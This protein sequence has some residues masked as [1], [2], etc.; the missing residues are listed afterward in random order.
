MPK[1]VCNFLTRPMEQQAERLNASKERVV[2]AHNLI[3][4]SDPQNIDPSD[5]QVQAVID[6]A[7]KR[8]KEAQERLAENKK[9]LTKDFSSTLVSIAPFRNYEGPKLAGDLS[10]AVAIRNEQIALEKLSNTYR[11]AAYAVAS[12][13]GLQIE[14]FTNTRGSF[15]NTVEPSFAITFDK[16]TADTKADE[17]LLFT[18]LMSDLGYEQQKTAYVTRYLSS[19]EDPNANAVEFSLRTNLATKTGNIPVS[20]ISARLRSMMNEEGLADEGFAVD[21]G[22]NEIRFLVADAEESQEAFQEKLGKYRKLLARLQSEILNK[23][24]KVEY[25]QTPAASADLNSDARRGIY[26]SWLDQNGSNHQK[27]SGDAREL[28]V[29][30]QRRAERLSAQELAERTREAYT[31]QANPAEPLTKEELEA[32]QSEVVSSMT[33]AA[34]A[35]EGRYLYRVAFQKDG[36]GNETM[37]I[38]TE[39][40]LTASDQTSTA[41]AKLHGTY[42]PERLKMR[43]D[44]LARSMSS[45]FELLA[46][47]KGKDI[48]SKI[49]EL[50]A[51]RSKAKPEEKP[52]VNRKIAK[53]TRDY[54][55]LENRNSGKPSARAAAINVVG[56]D[57]IVARLLS[58]LTLRKGTQTDYVATEYQKILDNFSAMQNAVVHRFAYLEG[59]ELRRNADSNIEDDDELG[60]Y[61]T[62]N[63][64]W[65]EEAHASDTFK[66]LSETVRSALKNCVLRENTPVTKKGKKVYPAIKDDL[67]QKMYMDPKA[68]YQEIAYVLSSM[69]DDSDFHNPA[70]DSYPALERMA[71]REGFSWVR[72]VVNYLKR[73]PDSAPLFYNAFRMDLTQFWHSD[74]LGR[75]KPV[76]ALPSGD[77]FLN[78]AKR[79]VQYSEKYADISL[80]DKGALSDFETIKTLS[81]MHSEANKI[82]NHKKFMESSEMQEEFA[83]DIANLI[84]ALGVNVSDDSITELVRAR[85]A[86]KEKHRLI[87]ATVEIG[88]IIG[89]AY[90]IKDPEKASNDITSSLAD[91]MFS[92][93]Y[94][95]FRRLGGEIEYFNGTSYQASFRD[96]GASFYAL[97]K[98]NFVTTTVKV[99]KLDDTQRRQEYMERMYRS[100]YFMYDSVN[101][102]KNVILDELWNPDN[103]KE[104]SILDICTFNS[105]AGHKFPQMTDEEIR[106]A[107]VSMFFTPEESGDSATTAAWYHVPNYSNA[108]SSDFIKYK[109]ER[110]KNYKEVLAG[111]IM[112]GVKQELNRIRLGQLRKE[113]LAQNTPDGGHSNLEEIARWDSNSTHFC[114]FPFF[115][116][117]TD[118]VTGLTLL[119]ASDKYYQDKDEKA[120]NAFIT[121]GIYA[122][123]RQTTDNYSYPLASFKDAYKRKAIEGLEKEKAQEL[124]KKISNI[125]AEEVRACL[126]ADD[127]TGFDKDVTGIVDL[128]ENYVW[129]TH[130]MLHQ[131]TEL[132]TCDLAFYKRGDQGVDLVKRFKEVTASGD[133]L[134]TQSK[135]GK[136][137]SAVIGIRDHDQT[138]LDY[139]Y[140][141]KSLQDALNEGRLSGPKGK[142]MAE[143]ILSHYEHMNITDGQSLRTLPS[144][145]SVM[146]MVGKWTPDLQD[147]YVRI[148]Q[149][150]YDEAD[151]YA[152]FVAIK[153][154]IFDFL[155]TET[156]VVGSEIG[157]DTDAPVTINVPTQYKDSEAVL[158]SLAGKLSGAFENSAKARGLERFMIDYGI[159][160][161][162]FESTTKVGL[163]GAIDLRYS[164]SFLENDAQRKA[165]IEKGFKEK[166]GEVPASWTDYMDF[167]REEYINSLKQGKISQ[168]AFN[169]IMA[170]MEPTEDEVYDLLSEATTPF[171]NEDVLPNGVQWVQNPNP[172]KDWETDGMSEQQAVAYRQNRGM[173]LNPQRVKF[174]DNRDYRIVQP[175]REHLF[176]TKVVLGVQ[177]KNLITA[178]LPENF[179]MT[180]RGRQFNAE[181]TR[182]FFHSLLVE[183]LL[184]DYTKLA[185]VFESPERLSEALQATVVGNPK[186]DDDILQALELETVT[187]PITGV[188]STKFHT[189]M[190][191]PANSNKLAEIILSLFKN[192]IA[193]QT[194]FGGAA[195][196]ETGW[197][198]SKDLHSVRDENGNLKGYECYLPAWS[199]LYFGKY[200]NPD[201][202]F[203]H[204]RMMKEHPELMRMVGYR[205]PTDHKHS[206]VPLIVKGFLPQAKGNQIIMAEEA[207]VAAGED[208]DIDKKYLIMPAFSIPMNKDKFRRDFLNFRRANGAKIAS[209][210]ELAEVDDAIEA[211]VEG[212]IQ[213]EKDS[214]AQAVMDFYTENAEKYGTPD[215]Q[216][217]EYDVTKSPEEQTRTQRNNMLFEMMYNILISPSVSEQT[218]MPTNFVSF[219]RGGFITNIAKSE[220]RKGNST[221]TPRELL[222]RGFKT[223]ENDSNKADAAAA[224]YDPFSPNNFARHHKANMDALKLVGIFAA[225]LTV[226]AKYQG[227]DSRLNKKHHFK[228]GDKLVTSL[229]ERKDIDDLLSSFNYSESI[230]A[231]TDNGKDPSVARLGITVDNAGLA[232]TMIST[233]A[234][235]NMISFFLNHP[236]RVRADG[237]PGDPAL[238]TYI[239][240]ILSENYARPKNEELLQEDGITEEELL[241]CILEGEE[242]YDVIE[243]Y[244]LSQQ[245][246]SESLVNPVVFRPTEEQI[247]MLQR[248]L[249]AILF[250]ENYQQISDVVFSGRTAISR[251]DSTNGAVDHRLGGVLA[252]QRAVDVFHRRIENRTVSDFN[253][254]RSFDPVIE[255]ETLDKT[256]PKNMKGLLEGKLTP[257][258]IAELRKAFNESGLPVA[259]AAHT[260]GIEAAQVFMGKYFSN[261]TEMVKDL[262]NEVMDNSAFPKSGTDAS[263]DYAVRVIQ[264]LTTY[265]LAGTDLF[266]DDGKHT[267]RQKREYYVYSYPSEFFKIVKENPELKELYYFGNIRMSNGKLSLDGASRISRDQRLQI[268]ADLDNVFLGRVLPEGLTEQEKQA[269]LAIYNRLIKDLLCYAFY[270]GQLTFGATNIGSFLSDDIKHA[271]PEYI[272]ALE[273]VDR[274]IRSDAQ[275]EHFMDELFAQ[276]HIPMQTIRAEKSEGLSVAEDGSMTIPSWEATNDFLDGKP[277][278]YLAVLV[279]WEEKNAAGETVTQTRVDRYKLVNVTNSGKT[280]HYTPMNLLSALDGTKF[281]PNSTFEEDNS[282]PDSTEKWNK[283]VAATTRQASVDEM[284]LNSLAAQ[285]EAVGDERFE[286][287]MAALDADL[288]NRT[289]TSGERIVTYSGDW[290]R[291][292]VAADSDSLYIFT[293]N[294]DRDSGSGNIPEDSWYSQRYGAGHHFPTMT[295]AVIRGLDNARPVSTQ[296]WYHEGAKGTTGRWNNEDFEAFKEVI[297]AE[298]ADIKAAW[299]TGKYSRIVLPSGDGL[300]NGRISQIT[301]ERTPDL[302]NYLQ[303]KMED[304]KTYVN[305]TPSASTTV[306][307]DSIDQQEDFLE[308]QNFDEFDAQL[309]ELES[310][311]FFNA[312]IESAI[313]KMEE[314]ESPE[315]L[316]GLDDFESPEDTTPYEPNTDKTGNPCKKL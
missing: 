131:I 310:S 70:N 249:K 219:K 119:G 165:N 279:Q 136:R 243:Q 220:A 251:A 218:Q 35:F 48:Q 114:M 199:K 163:Q 76:N 216:M 244:K 213:T 146:D 217:I 227:T 300:F 281:N 89:A 21:A 152:V 274:A 113:K 210:S 299:D 57:A 87:D 203:D 71:E 175:T 3:A 123:L 208:K 132:L 316:E 116:S 260:L 252:Q 169:E 173:S 212:S 291:V 95:S 161:A 99:L 140:I 59:V 141:R 160:I 258:K 120:F 27:L 17:I 315:G 97:E 253:G 15:E 13:L 93:T 31:L 225:N 270:T 106:T 137:Y 248:N 105:F 127:R 263:T 265:A 8:A 11:D 135:Y 19:A 294:T 190:G 90:K 148:M 293:D 101:G 159:D 177:A 117:W 236:S 37:F 223:L 107:E 25:D 84:R 133:A 221:V 167:A 247:K 290:K 301:Q 304:L 16:E 289:K 232:A 156:G 229:V 285:I 52:A 262:F 182:K 214:I 269:K 36:R 67:G 60:A 164:P 312:D 172:Y 53:L 314:E 145:R 14:T 231:S 108:Q 179:S 49:E 280:A 94:N 33:N 6:A 147:A 24:G 28:I 18:A 118:P 191:D 255:L 134:Y 20:R 154:F 61:A 295:A 200:L 125:K 298:F 139:N 178:D 282:L 157:L 111:K 256:Y 129:N 254:D 277:T 7:V 69:V 181:E 233:G 78:D 63:D 176:D 272:E 170:E 38:Y 235:I 143:F 194:I 283:H 303:A 122:M 110:G 158:M 171:S 174:I 202:S 41:L 83:L 234:S 273:H 45:T 209:N 196:I 9:N 197:S 162:K 5:E 10:D 130:F 43:V 296:R 268:K 189:P 46:V 54:D 205:I 109:R 241:Q 4:S 39:E 180:I 245:S 85:V 228:I 186:Y 307:L 62:G 102:W 66:G 47:Q 246:A 187:D 29:Q 198:F 151:L 80:W 115:E 75:C 92:R 112:V 275:K 238:K 126:E 81:E 1:L 77:A 50:K 44:M 153:P 72:D 30:A 58:D 74:E 250:L 284:L 82:L 211:L 311:G 23:D 91:S 306:D 302:Y 26:A 215:I 271:F 73:N 34:K 305:S 128:I 267:M 142:E 184:E 226:S 230:N 292:D 103:R 121:R 287:M 168:E 185:E 264:G 259:Q 237:S 64:G 240:K 195:V 65:G 288:N 98:P 56:I 86:A 206:M 308:G 32:L 12:A 124:S 51:L 96:A 40:N 242:L 222:S 204:D 192:R 257:A 207:I 166:Y 155:P 68:A 100:N 266:G 224:P 104:R 149:G 276:N 261:Y 2:I 239:H 313:A 42:T 138:S 22:R 188:T 150:R 55:A 286:E 309:D 278:K 79:A 88:N 193:K 201:G 297:D 144:L 183:N